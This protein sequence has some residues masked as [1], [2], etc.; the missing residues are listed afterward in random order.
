MLTYVSP[1][2]IAV[3]ITINCLSAIGPLSLSGVIEPF[4]ETSLAGDKKAIS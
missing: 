3:A 1:L 4:S 2:L